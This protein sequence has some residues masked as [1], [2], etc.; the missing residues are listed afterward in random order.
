MRQRIRR[1]RDDSGTIPVGESPCGGTIAVRE[2]ESTILPVE[3]HSTD[4]G[5]LE[6]QGRGQ[7]M[8]EG[9]GV[10]AEGEGFF[11]NAPAAGE[12][13]GGVDGDGFG[14][15]SD[16]VNGEIFDHEGVVAAEGEGAAP[17]VG[18][19]PLSDEVEA[20]EARVRPFGSVVRIGGDEFLLV[21]P[22]MESSQAAE[23][24]EGIREDVH[25]HWSYGLATGTPDDT[26][27][28]I[29]DRADSAL[30]AQKQHR[31]GL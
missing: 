27:H 6:I 8:E 17:T 7:V 23:L 19:K 1:H 10:V 26:A 4:G 9:P 22:A 31:K 28:T 30:Y 3:G 18:G 2:G 11:V 16:E 5:Q 13:G 15:E 29:R 12:V 24:L 20:G 14:V 25:E 21:L